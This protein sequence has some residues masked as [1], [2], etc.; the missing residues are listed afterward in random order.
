MP[1]P[2]KWTFMGTIEQTRTNETFLSPKTLSHVVAP[3]LV[4][5]ELVESAKPS[6][7]CP[8]FANISCF[9]RFLSHLHT[10]N[11]EK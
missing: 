4:R 3:K 5:N 9:L 1:L 8:S 2:F 10:Q 11:L 6:I 7:L